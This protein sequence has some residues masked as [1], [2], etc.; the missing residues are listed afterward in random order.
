MDRHDRDEVVDEVLRK[1]AEPVERREG[2]RKADNHQSVEHHGGEH[3]GS[4]G[5]PPGRDCR[6][7]RSRRGVDELAPIFQGHQPAPPSLLCN[8][9]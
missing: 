1:I 4:V 3:R 8:P 9:R 5:W 6:S 2:R 7:G